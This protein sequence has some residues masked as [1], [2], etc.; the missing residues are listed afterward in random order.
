MI[1]IATPISH[2]FK[3]SE[4]ARKIQQASDC[5]ECR[6]WCINS[7]WPRQELIHFEANINFPWS[8]D[9]KA[10]FNRSISQKHDLRL[11]TFQMSTSWTNPTIVDGMY[12]P[13]GIGLSPDEMLNNVERNIKWLRST[14]SPKLLIGIENNNYYP[15]QAYD[16]IADTNFI[17]KVIEGNDVCFLFDV[18][19]AKISACNLKRRYD[20]YIA[21]LPL[22]RIVQIHIC[23]PEVDVTDFAWDTHEY[24]NEEIKNAVIDISREYRPSYLTIEYY[25]DAD[26]LLQTLD[27]F[28]ILRDK[29]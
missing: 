18:A 13:G 22:K 11:I 19:H 25:K 26:R 3:N 23:S 6:D 16:H 14:L 29:L 27:E 9:E 12:Q 15:T 28:T 17:K 4:H 2:L 7:T 5:L 21:E 24:P 10:Y 1:K 20:D 8:I